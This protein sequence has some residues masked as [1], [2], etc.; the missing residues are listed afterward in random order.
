MPKTY[1]LMSCVAQEI[2]RSD[3]DTIWFSRLDLKHDY[4][5][6]SL[7]P[8]VQSHSN[9]RQCEEESNENTSVPDRALWANRNASL[10]QQALDKISRDYESRT[11]LLDD[12]LL[13]ITGD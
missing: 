7:D 5:Q 4:S 8:V 12:I 3:K 2:T 11:V 13:V 9:L 1:I 6:V 10:L